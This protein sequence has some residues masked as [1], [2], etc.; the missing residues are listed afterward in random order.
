MCNE[1]QWMINLLKADFLQNPLHHSSVL[2]LD[3]TS[4]YSPY[5]GLTS[6]KVDSSI[7][8]R[9]MGYGIPAILP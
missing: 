1:A 3:H 8:I 5:L 7:S 9:F 4:N 2:R 6:A